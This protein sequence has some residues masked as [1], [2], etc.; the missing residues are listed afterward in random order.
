MDFTSLVALVNQGGPTVALIVITV[1]FLD[2]IRQTTST[3]MLANKSA[4]DSS[5]AAHK[6]STEAA[7]QAHK[8]C[9]EKLEMSNQKLIEVVEDNTKAFI[10]LKE[11]I[12]QKTT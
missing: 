3:A 8:L 1:I 2:H 4:I 7:L 9:E 5:N 6:L 10:E 11:I 12:R